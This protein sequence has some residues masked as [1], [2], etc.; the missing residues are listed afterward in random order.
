MG[1]V[2]L[3]QTCCPNLFRTGTMINIVEAGDK[4]AGDNFAFL[5]MYSK[6]CYTFNFNLSY[7]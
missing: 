3:K 7:L 2:Y 4:S 1:D 6:Y 5:F